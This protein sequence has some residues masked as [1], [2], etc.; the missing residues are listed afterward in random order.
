MLA[1]VVGLL[2]LAPPTFFFSFFVSIGEFWLQLRL[3]TQIEMNLSGVR[4]EMGRGFSSLADGNLLLPA[5]IIVD[6][7]AAAAVAPSPSTH[8]H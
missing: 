4:D 7:A 8:Q 3:A 5:L 6:A 2:P 1:D